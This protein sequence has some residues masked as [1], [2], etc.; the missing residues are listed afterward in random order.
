[1]SLFCLL[2]RM[3]Q[4]HEAV[5][6]IAKSVNPF[7]SGPSGSNRSH[8]VSIKALIKI[9]QDMARV[10][11]RLTTP[12]APIDFVRK[13]EVEEFHGTILEG[14]DKAEFWLE[15]LQRAL[16]EVKCP[17]EQKAKCVVSLLQ[18]VA[19]DWWKLVLR[20][21]LLLEPNSWDLFAQEFQTKYVTD[22]YKETK[23]KQFLNMKQGNLIVVEYEKEFSRL[24]KYASEL[25][26]DPQFCPSTLV[27]ILWVPY[28]PIVLIWHR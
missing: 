27:F 14:S 15:N 18:G 11:D 12:R 5:E 22:D 24:S 7:V 28:S 1:M 17:P 26:V 2:F 16:D 4:A 8:H 21:P 25:V 23:W 9:S 3:D 19:Y 20:N 6:G 10:L 13:H